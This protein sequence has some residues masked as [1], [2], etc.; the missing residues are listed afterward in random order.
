[1]EVVGRNKDVPIR[2]VALLFV[3]VGM[4]P[5]HFK[6]N[7]KKTC[8]DEWTLA[9]EFFVISQFLFDISFLFENYLPHFYKDMVQILQ[10][11]QLTKWG[12]FNLQFYITILLILLQYEIKTMKI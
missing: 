10:I 12:S 7:K 6:I 8:M 1:M 4:G 11:K 5:K 9:W 2:S 3:M